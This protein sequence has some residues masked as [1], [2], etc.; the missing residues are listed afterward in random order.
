MTRPPGGS[1]PPTSATFDGERIALTPLAEAVAERYFAEF[2]GDLERYGDA[3]RAWEIH[4]TLYCLN[5]ALLDVQGYTSLEKQI[6]WLAGIL[7]TRDFPLAQLARNLELAADVAEER[8]GAPVAARLRS[9][10]QLVAVYR[11]P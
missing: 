6:T 3:G 2:P 11:L 4:D 1:P 5:W 9:A 10:A 7:A 8:I